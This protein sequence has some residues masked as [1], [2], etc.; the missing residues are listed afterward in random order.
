MSNKLVNLTRSGKIF[1]PGSGGGRTG[2]TGRTGHVSSVEE[3]WND[4]AGLLIKTG[5]H[6]KTRLKTRCW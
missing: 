4:G 3:G 1:V 5:Q 6:F 2:W